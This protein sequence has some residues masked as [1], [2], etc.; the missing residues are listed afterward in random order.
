MKLSIITINYN[1]KEGL[2]KTIDSVICQT[3]KDYEWIVIDGGS[4]DGSKELIEQY[5][6]YFAY[7][8]SEPDNGIY[9][10]MNKG[11]VKAKG[12]Y[13]NF[14]N[15]GDVFHDNKVLAVVFRK[16]LYGDILIGQVKC[17]GIDLLVNQFPLKACNVGW[18]RVDEGFCHQG[19]FSKLELVHAHPFDETLKIASD[20]KFWCQTII[21]DNKSVQDL[22][23]IVADYDMNG[24]SSNIQNDDLQSKERELI[25]KS[26]FPPLILKE[27]QDYQTLRN[28]SYVYDMSYI[29]RH[30]Y[31]VFVGLRK[32]ISLIYRVLYKTSA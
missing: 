15:S 8:C 29:E 7:W 3:W 13:V 17:M 26:L 10:A 32:L 18:Q 27:L 23:M 30:F 5:Q 16:E 2:Q 31:G 4:T 25:K 11:A 21:L 14:M 20:W 22:E 9:N 12:E 1:N 24:I 28:S 19:T 6:E